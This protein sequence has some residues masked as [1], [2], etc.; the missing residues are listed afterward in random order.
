MSRGFA[1][2]GGGRERDFTRG[3]IGRQIF[4]LALPIMGTAFILMGFNL[5]DMFWLGHEGSLEVSGVGAA[6]I[7]L[8]LGNALSTITKLGA[9]ITISQSL[10]AGYSRLASR[11]ARHAV[12]LALVIGLL[13]GAT[14][15]FFNVELVAVF[16]LQD[17]L[18]RG[19]AEEY[20]QIV[21]FSLVVTFVNST[22]FGL[23]NGF[24]NSRLPFIAFS[25]GLLLNIVLDPVMIRG[26]LGF[27]AMGVAGAAWATVISQVVT[28]LI[29]LLFNVRPGAIFHRLL[30]GFR[31]SLVLARR[32]LRLGLPVA[33]QSA[34][35]ATIGLVIARLVARWGDVGVGVQSLGS[36]MEAI[37]WMT[38]GGFATAL[39][40]FVGQN[41]GGGNIPRIRAGYRRTLLFTMSFGVFATFLFI[42]FGEPLFALFVPEREAAVAGGVYL[43]ILGFSQVFMVLEIT[44]SGVFNGVGRTLPPAIVGIA[45]NLLRIPLALWWGAYSLEGIW[46]AISVSSFLKGVTLWVWL[47]VFARRGFGR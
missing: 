4:S 30:R 17:S 42:F 8:W 35:F 29:F 33:A 34:L 23:Y 27:P 13:Y 25:C 1:L 40:S 15:F 2:A 10:G 41:W 11:Y 3:P 6:G 16:G 14:L 43:R 20:L 31:P 28:L 22:Y 12:V 9:E 26:W 32:I 46:W 39:G 21:S 37:S 36:Q 45:F 18:T 38:A 5:A 44:S 7:Y 24:G 19:F 47:R